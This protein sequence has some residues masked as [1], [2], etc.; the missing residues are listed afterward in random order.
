MQF[1]GAS[2]LHKKLLTYF[3]EV[4]QEAH[5]QLKQKLLEAILAFAN[6]PKMVLNRLCL[7]V[8]LL[9]FNST[10]IPLLLNHPFPAARHL[11]HQHASGRMANSH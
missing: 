1:F 2:T 3:P 6:G 7:A 9:L 8:S 4:P 5:E 10:S 11:C